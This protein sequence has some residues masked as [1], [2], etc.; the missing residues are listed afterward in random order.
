MN[1][2]FTNTDTGKGVSSKDSNPPGKRPTSQGLNPTAPAFTPKTPISQSSDKDK[3]PSGL[4]PS[5]NDTEFEEEFPGLTETHPIPVWVSNE[6]GQELSNSQLRRRR[7]WR[8]AAREAE[9]RKEE[10]EKADLKA[11]YAKLNE[12]EVGPAEWAQRRQNFKRKGE[13]FLNN[14][15]PRDGESK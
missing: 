2:F 3:T 14:V 10:K 5:N 7:R 11:E 9:E 1:P 15:K 4:G 8:K 13:G 6:S 12:Q